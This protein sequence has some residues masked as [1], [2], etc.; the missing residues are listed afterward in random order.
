MS[1]HRNAPRIVIDLDLP[2]PVVSRHLYGHFAEHLGRCIY[3][4]FWV[5]ED[6]STPNL[7]GIR[8]DVV[9]ALR[10]LRV[11]NLRW[12]G[13]CFADEYHWRDGIGPRSERPRMVN[14]HW[15]DVVEDNSF[16]THEFLA[17]CELL[18]ADPYVNGNVGSGTV[19]EL[20][21]WIE[22]LTRADDSP[23]AALRRR[24]GRDQPWRVPFIGIG[25]EPWGC[26][27]NMRAEAYADLA[28]RYATYVRNHG[29]NQ[30]Y[31]I[32]A[33][34]NADDYAWTEALM[35]ALGCVSCGDTTAFEAVSLHYYTM[36]G[37][38]ADKG[39]ATSFGQDDYYRTMAA[40]TRIDEL[41][42]RH[43]TVMDRYDPGRR[44]GLVLDEWGTWW[45][46]ED[47]TNPGFL[48][49]Q[50]TLRDALVASV[51]FDAFHRHADRLV[52]ANIAQTVN[53]LQAM[54]LTDPETGA[55]VLTP[56]YH[57]FAM[58]TGHHDAASLAVHI[59]GAG[60]R[61]VAGGTLPLLSAS[62]TT[63]G[64]TALVSITNLD[65]DAGCTTVLDLR[66][67]GVT[68]HSATI[69]T[70]SAIQAHN[71][72]DSPDQVRPQAFEGVRPHPR[73]LQL[74]LPAHSYVTVELALEET[75]D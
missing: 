61:Q 70:A 57:V 64:D 1:D 58:N 56:T 52:M 49:Q 55:L 34:A 36:S 37:T 67:R 18:G 44:I 54:I 27:G 32:A 33:G 43:S 15:G 5:G 19:R 65:A 51:H 6:S 26:G 60:T 41:L 12:P 16:G 59:V 46:V 50:N 40:A 28:R 63:R 17:L 68:G 38:W 29:E 4:G 31:R 53:V 45:N 24:N 23:M 7:A 48:Y 10:A 74:E 2:G 69:L 20:S 42:T 39:H 66:G 35:K 3:G 47:G 75:D 25:N 71:T 62:A 14:S 8:A 9:E 73:G 72:P 11:P 13:G 30:V 22:Y 21:E